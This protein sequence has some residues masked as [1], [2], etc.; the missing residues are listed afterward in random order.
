MIRMRR[1]VG[2]FGLGN[3]ACSFGTCV[4]AQTVERDTTITGPRGRTIKRHVE[5]QRGPGSIDRSVQI[6]RPGGTLD[7]QVQVQRSP[8]MGPWRPPMG[9]PWPRPAWFPAACG[10]W[11]FRQFG[12]G[13]VAAPMLNF[14][15]GGGGGGIGGGL[16]GPGPGGGGPGG[17][18][19]GAPPPP[20][21]IALMT[22]R[23]QSYYPQPPQGCGLHA[24]TDW[25]PARDSFADPCPE[26]RLDRKTCESPRRSRWVRSAARI[27]RSRSNV[28]R[29]MTRRKR[30]ARQ[31][32]R[33]S[34][35]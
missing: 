2:L 25:R 1:F 23:L 27:P 32:R 3:G 15:F 7:R 35:G 16:G 24:G 11:P 9:G 34:N 14:S 29:F 21:Q 5:I 22:Q 28:A 17:P 13:L 6:Q 18:G 26:V 20:D 10:G 33:L 31:R 19:A 8:L 4:D 12:F 30:S